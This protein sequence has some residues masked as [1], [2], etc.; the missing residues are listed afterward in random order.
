MAKTKGIGLSVLASIKQEAA[1]K[2]K[3]KAEGKATT[4]ETEHNPAYSAD[5]LERLLANTG[6]IV[7]RDG[8]LLLKPAN[9]GARRGKAPRL[10]I[11]ATVE[12]ID[13]LAEGLKMLIADEEAMGEK[14]AD[15]ERFIA[16]KK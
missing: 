13:K 11:K 5:E 16:S 14:R 10:L 3:A 2:A 9:T 7:T 12:D 8:D 6:V 15:F 1:D 4:G